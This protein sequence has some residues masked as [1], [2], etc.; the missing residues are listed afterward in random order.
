MSLQLL[1]S[2]DLFL[3]LIVNLEDHKCL[4]MLYIDMIVLIFNRLI[5]IYLVISAH[6]NFFKFCKKAILAL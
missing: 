6:M 2:Q 5:I 4:V 3:Y 1:K